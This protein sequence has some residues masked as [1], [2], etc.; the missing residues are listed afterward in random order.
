M[1]LGNAIFGNSRGKYEFLDRE[2]ENS[3]SWKDLM[4]TL[5]ADSYG[6]L[7]TQ[8]YDEKLD[9]YVE[10]DNG[11]T[12]NEFGGYVCRDEGG[13]VVFEIFP[14]YWLNDEKLKEKPNFVYRPGTDKEISIKWYKYPFRDAYVMQP[15]SKPMLKRAWEDCTNELKKEIER[16]KH[17]NN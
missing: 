2:L 12:A 1:E 10:R 7:D 6:C 5:Q 16:K 13:E 8:Y 15:V 4:R 11:L 17:A 14:Y 3:R 9:K